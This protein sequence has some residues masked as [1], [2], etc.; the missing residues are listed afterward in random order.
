[1]P[2]QSRETNILKQN[3]RDSLKRTRKLE[4]KNEELIELLHENKNRLRA[5]RQKLA[6]IRRKL[7]AENAMQ[8]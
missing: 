5:E 6:S 7:D 4:E 2:K 1:M 8:L 3:L